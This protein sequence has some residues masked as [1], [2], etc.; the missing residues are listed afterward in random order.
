MKFKR[1]FKTLI[2]LSLLVILG[3]FSFGQFEEEEDG[4]REAFGWSNLNLNTTFKSI[5][6]QKLPGNQ[7]KLQ[8]D[9]LKMT[10]IKKNQI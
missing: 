6:I 7:F 3:G 9:G 1:I 8:M 2:V 5:K 4:R 10:N